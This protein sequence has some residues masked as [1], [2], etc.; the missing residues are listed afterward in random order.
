MTGRGETQSRPSGTRDLTP[1]T[2]NLK[3]E[4]CAQRPWGP[5]PLRGSGW[6]GDAVNPLR[7]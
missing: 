5:S 6:R 1:E 4:T 2:R 7:I 3:P